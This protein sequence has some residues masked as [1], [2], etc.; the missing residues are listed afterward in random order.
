[1]HASGAVSLPTQHSVL[2]P[3]ILDNKLQTLLHQ[4]TR[5]IGSL[6]Q[7]LRGEI[8][9]IGE[10]TDALKTKCDELVQYVQALEEEN[11]ALKHPVSQ[12]QLQ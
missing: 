6:A 8:S 2:T 3:E 11:A 9:Q 10:H 5:N 12:M 7:E 1:M 4:L